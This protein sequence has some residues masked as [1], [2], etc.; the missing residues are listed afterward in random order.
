MDEFDDTG[1]QIYSD[2]QSEISTPSN[3]LKNIFSFHRNPSLKRYIIPGLTTILLMAGLITGTYLVQQSQDIRR[4]AY[5]QTADTWRTGILNSRDF[6]RTN[7]LVEEAP[8]YAT[9]KNVSQGTYDPSSNKTFIVYAGGLMN[10]PDDGEELS[11]YDPHIIAFN[12]TTNTWEGPIKIYTTNLPGDNHHYPQMIIDGQGYLH[13]FE[14]FHSRNNLLYA[15]SNSPRSITSGW[16]TS[17]ISNTQHNT[18]AGAFIDNQGE[19]YIFFRSSLYNANSKFYELEQYVKSNNN[20]QS[21]QGPFNVIDPG[22]P[23]EYCSANGCLINDSGWSTVYVGD[24]LQD[25]T[26]NLLYITFSDTHTHDT[27]WRGSRIIKFDF[28]N[29]NVYSLGG[30]NLGQSVDYTEF[31]T[32][33]CCTL[34]SRP[35]ITREAMDDHYM[36]F[37]QIIVIE[38]QVNR[39]PV[40]YYNN[41]DASWNGRMYKAVWTGSSWQETDLFN[42][43]GS[44]SAIR[45]AE[46]SQSH[47][48]TLYFKSLDYDLDYPISSLPQCMDYQN[49]LRIYNNSPFDRWS[50]IRLFGKSE[51]NGQATE[52]HRSWELRGVSNFSLIHDSHPAIKATL[53]VPK[54]NCTITSVVK[55]GNFEKVYP[56]GAHYV[57]GTIPLDPQASAPSCS[58]WTDMNVNGCSFSEWSSSPRGSD[59]LTTGTSVNLNMSV[60][61]ADYMQ[62]ANVGVETCADYSGAWSS[63]QDYSS[64]RSWTITS[65]LEEKKV[66]GRFTGPGSI[67]QCGGRVELVSSPATPTPTPIPTNTP[68]PTPTNTPVPTRTP[69]PSP[70]NTPRPTRTPTPTR[71]PQPTNTPTPTPT[72]GKY[73]GDADGDGDID[74]DDYIIWES[75]YN[76]PPQPDP[77]GDAD[78]N[79]DGQVDGLDYIIW[80]NNYTG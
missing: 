13:V 37:R 25:K 6:Y 11:A 49:A 53:I 67:V 51:T 38:D 69:T 18:Y 32:N 76:K 9:S 44:V 30:A 23:S 29:D 26:N 62:F 19:I 35:E 42:T 41:P 12:H 73:M 75:Q 72:A 17:F 80:L 58:S 27:L 55:N 16:T 54:Y 78:F 7:F 46:Y 36:N 33:N 45:D 5:F 68:T 22:G 14:S 57:L 39:N 77:S 21:W 28:A 59:C 56:I 63:K 71:T 60:A 61:N 64:Q 52:D 10:D 24:M 2:S 74:K 48:T 43:L 70:T 15:K 3:P 4:K 20:G 66:C 8:L 47:G 40:V 31:Y 34:F 79:T 1:E 50:D 65:G